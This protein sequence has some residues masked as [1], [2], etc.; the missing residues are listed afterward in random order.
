MPHVQSCGIG[1]LVVTCTDQHIPKCSVACGSIFERPNEGNVAQY[2]S[3]GHLSV[4]CDALGPI[5][6]LLYSVW[7]PLRHYN[8][9]CSFA[10]ANHMEHKIGRLVYLP[11]IS[12]TPLASTLRGF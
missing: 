3:I 8:C 1:A 7:L 6:M 4:A 5:D 2:T 10:N 11:E 9:T 12:A